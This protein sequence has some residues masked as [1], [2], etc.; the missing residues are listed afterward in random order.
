L[1]LTPILLPV[2]LIAAGDVAGQA[3]ASDLT[4]LIST[5]GEKNVALMIAA[6]IG[7][8]MVWA[9]R[10]PGD[11]KGKSTAPVGQALASA[12]VMILIISAGGAFGYVVRQMDI[13]ATVQAMLPTSKLALL[14]LAF[15]LATSV[16]TAQ[17]SA[18]VAMITATGM[19]SP[20]AAAGSLG[21]SPLYLALAIGCGSKPISWMNDAGFWIIS[22]MSGMTE[23]ET[24]KTVSVMLA[25]MGVV[26]LMAT[27]LGAWLIPLN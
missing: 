4:R 12:G 20:I 24:L 27:M 1:A 26:G 19:V 15:L 9:R 14:P 7:L 17:G 13:S 22:K 5:L 11:A 10:K 6:G 23:T 3:K 8:L 2:V 21:Y 16:R 25:I 18:M